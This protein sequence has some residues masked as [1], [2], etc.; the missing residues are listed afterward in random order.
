MTAGFSIFDF[1]FYNLFHSFI[2]AGLN[3]RPEQ[4]KTT[5]V[6]VCESNFLYIML[7]LCFYF[8][9]TNWEPMFYKKYKQYELQCVVKYFSKQQRNIRTSAN[10]SHPLRTKFCIA[11]RISQSSNRTIVSSVS[12][13]VCIFIA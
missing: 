6:S 5:Q 10:S 12:I 4:I 7:F 2:I 13:E 3:A 9:S 1:T 11:F 8:N